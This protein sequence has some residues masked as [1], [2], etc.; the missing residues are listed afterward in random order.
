MGSALTDGEAFSQY[1]E[2][3]SALLAVDERKREA[4]RNAVRTA[5][6]AEA[7]VKSSLAAQ[8]RMYD[9]AAADADQA[10]RLLSEV[11]N[12]LGIHDDFTGA[13]APQASRPPA[14]I[15]LRNRIHEVYKWADEAKPAAESLLRS[16]GRLS[17]RIAAVEPPP[18]RRPGSAARRSPA[19]AA[20]IVGVLIVVVIVI[21]V[22][23]H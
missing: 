5:S 21:V 3:M 7:E 6:A 4:L 13:L 1:R 16:R 9:R 17:R 14:L 11:A 22:A 20:A 8:Q 18:V 12:L 19:V 2:A 10:Q 15:E 23:S